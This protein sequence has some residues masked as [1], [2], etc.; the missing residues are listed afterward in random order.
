MDFKLQKKEIHKQA[1]GRMFD[2]ASSNILNDST[3]IPLP[4]YDNDG[5]FRS[6]IQ[7]RSGFLN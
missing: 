3:E 4:R 5:I 6:Y 1:N 7:R 2:L